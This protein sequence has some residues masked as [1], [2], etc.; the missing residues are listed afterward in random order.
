MRGRTLHSA[1]EA[2]LKKLEE[3]TTFNF[4][5]VP[6]PKVIEFIRDK[7]HMP[8]LLDAKAVA[9]MGVK[10]DEPITISVADIPLRSAIELALSDL[11]LTWMIGHDVLLITSQEKSKSSDFMVVK[12]YDVSDLLV[13]R[14]NY[15]FPEPFPLERPRQRVVFVAEWVPSVA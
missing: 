5:Q 15:P 6:L 1:E 11:G 3:P 4:A 10:A 9:D 2:I 13:E 12:Y 7:H 8:V 14:C